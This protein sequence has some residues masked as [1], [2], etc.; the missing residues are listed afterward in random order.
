MFLLTKNETPIT[1]HILA[2]PEDGGTYLAKYLAFPVPRFRWD[3]L[4]PVS[5]IVLAQLPLNAGPD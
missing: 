3:Q 2:L 4:R 5:Q 1:L